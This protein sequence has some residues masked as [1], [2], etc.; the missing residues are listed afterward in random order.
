MQA[1][2]LAEAPFDSDSELGGGVASLGLGGASVSDLTD[3]ILL[4][5][6]GARNGSASNE[7]FSASGEEL[8]KTDSKVDTCQYWNF[9]VGAWDG[10]GCIAVGA[11]LVSGKL[12]CHCYH[13]TD[14]G[15]VASDVIPKM[16]MPD[17][18]NPGAAFKS[19]S[20]D[21]ITV[22]AVLGALLITYWALVYWGWNKDRHDARLAAKGL[23]SNDGSQYRKSLERQRAEQL[24]AAMASNNPELTKRLMRGSLRF[25][26]M[27]LRVRLWATLTSK[28]KLLGGFFAVNSNYTRPRRFTVLFCMLVGNM[29]VNALWIGSGQ[30]ETF[31]QKALAGVIS[32]IIMFPVA[33]F[34][35]WIFMNLEISPD[36]QKVRNQRQLAAKAHEVQE[37]VNAIGIGGKINGPRGKKIAAPSPLIKRRPPRRREWVPAPDFQRIGPG[38]A[39]PDTG[40]SP[41]KRV[42]LSSP[43]IAARGKNFEERAVHMYNHDDRSFISVSS[44][45]RESSDLHPD[46][47]GLMLPRRSLP[48]HNGPHHPAPIPV[49]KDRGHPHHASSSDEEPD[50]LHLHSSSPAQSKNS[51]GSQTSFT[52]SNA[53]Q[54]GRYYHGRNR[55]SS[56]SES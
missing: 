41:Y 3:P 40:I 55:N 47:T 7:T 2:G 6:P 50:L 11:D 1:T 10:R 16:S 26:F 28:H 20:A 54:Q 17:P 51:S 29:F 5:M 8:D 25:K 32:A 23:L 13:L 49:E 31:I 19:F 9:A 45:N 43:M 27:A 46:Y 34:F 52:S 4:E 53:R 14:F 15:G 42:S 39:N 36:R 12:H 35:A 21:D 30:Q 18:T 38:A 22:V 56:K 24:D 48:I 44:L 33:F 37:V